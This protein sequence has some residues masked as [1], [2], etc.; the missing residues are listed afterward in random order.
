MP[1]PQEAASIIPWIL[2]LG[3]VFEVLK[4][5]WAS[6]QRTPTFLF[7]FLCSFILLCSF[8]NAQTITIEGRLIDRESKSPI[9][10]I[11]ISSS[12][13]EDS[14]KEI[15]ET[16]AITDDNGLFKFDLNILPNENDLC[17][18]IIKYK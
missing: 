18:P 16:M 4:S 10:N 7:V 13:Y 2:P 11:E 9:P 15:I 1:Y 14:G 12:F 5:P 3:L 8:V 17:K 6:I